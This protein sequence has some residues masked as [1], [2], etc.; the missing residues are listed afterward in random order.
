MRILRKGRLD[1][2]WI[3]WGI[4]K[5]N[6]S[7]ENRKSAVSER[8]GLGEPCPPSP[9]ITCHHPPPS[10]TGR[11]VLPPQLGRLARS[12]VRTSAP[13]IASLRRPNGESKMNRVRLK[14]PTGR[15]RRFAGR[16]ASDAAGSAE[17]P[18]AREQGRSQAEAAGQE[19]ALGQ[20]PAVTTSPPVRG[21]QGLSGS[22]FPSADRDTLASWGQILP[23]G[24]Q[25]CH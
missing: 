5:I 13:L 2:K 8:R 17:P 12:G 23:P 16:A 6:N 24:K 4:G 1:L 18:G 7:F 19:V 9:P 11:F 14:D 10:A 20:T 21:Q 22:Y 25:S 15:G 3:C